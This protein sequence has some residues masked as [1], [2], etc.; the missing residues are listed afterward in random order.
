MLKSFKY[1]FSKVCCNYLSSHPG[2]VI[3][4]DKLA[5]LVGEAWPTSFTAVNVMSGFKKFGVYPFNPGEVTDGQLAPS[6]ALRPQPDFI[7]SQSPVALYSHWNRKPC[8]NEDMKSTMTL[9]NPVAIHG[10]KITTQRLKLVL[11]VNLKRHHCRLG[12]RAVTH[13]ML[14]VSKVLVLPEPQAKPTVRRKTTPTKK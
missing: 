1:S 5:S 8:I 12:N 7:H 13:R 11:L 4:P 14:H 3:S 6:K 9:V 10:L 2:R